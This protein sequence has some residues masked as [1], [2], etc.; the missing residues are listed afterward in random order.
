MQVLSLLVLPNSFLKFL[1]RDFSGAPV[2]KTTHSTARVLGQGLPDQGTRAHTLQLKKAW[3]RREN[4]TE[5]KKGA[6]GLG[7]A[8]MCEAAACSLR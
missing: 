4:I 7:E 5:K 6:V 8:R 3:R 1:Q 2:A